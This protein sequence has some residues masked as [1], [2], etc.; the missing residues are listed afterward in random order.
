LRTNSFVFVAVYETRRI[1]ISPFSP[2]NCEEQL[3]S[4]QPG[5]MLKIL[6]LA[7]VFVM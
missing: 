1:F 2:M 5:V 7:F 3:Y 4:L 6:I